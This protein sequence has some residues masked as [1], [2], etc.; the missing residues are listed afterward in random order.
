MK[1]NY[2]LWLDHEH[3]QEK[4]LAKLPVCTCCG[5]PIQDEYGYYIDK[6]WFCEDCMRAEFRK[7]IEVD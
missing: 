6:E 1:D 3:E 4:W 5:E 2:D 7:S